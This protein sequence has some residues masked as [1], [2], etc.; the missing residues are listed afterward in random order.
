MRS[1]VRLPEG[2]FISFEGEFK[3]QQEAAR[4][5]ALLSTLVAVVIALLLYGY[6]RSGLLAAQVLINIPL[7]LVGG[8]LFTW[9]QIDNI[10]I[11]TLVGFIAVGG[12]AARNDIMLL[13]H[14]LHLM[15]HEGEGFTPQ[16]IVRGTLERLVPVLM[17]ALSAGIALVPLILAAGEPG[18]E[19]LYPVAVV[20]VG[21]L[22]VG[23]LLDLAV[24][25]A[26]FFHFG[27]KAAEKA[28]RLDSPAAQ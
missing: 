27:R 9:W 7:A 8:L 13:S 18:K 20:I 26:V 24:T 3:S 2:Y 28:L 4:R 5:I 22:V 17:T 1:K 14:F 19:I 15:R 21:G 6:F 23:T 16:M 12:I 25:P 10:S 11:A